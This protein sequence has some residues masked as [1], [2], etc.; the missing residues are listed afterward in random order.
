MLFVS[1]AGPDAVTGGTLMQFDS[2]GSGSLFAAGPYNLTGIAFDDDG[3]LYVGGYT[4]NGIERFASDGSHSTFVGPGSPGAPSDFS[5]FQP[6][7]I[8]FDS[9]GNLFVTGSSS[10]WK[11]TPSGTVSLFATF[12]DVG[13]PQDVAFD[14]EGNIYVSLSASRINRFLP[15]G[16]SLG[17]FVALPGLPL[18]IAF[19]ASDNLYIAFGNTIRKHDSSGT[20]L[21]DFDIVSA[22]TLGNG[23]YGLVFDPTSGDLYASAG[24]N[25]AIYRFDSNGALLGAF[26]DAGDGLSRPTFLAFSTAAA[27]PEPSAYAALV[28]MSALCVTAVWRRRNRFISPARCF[29]RNRTFRCAVVVGFALMARLTHAQTLIANGSFEVPSAGIQ[30]TFVVPSSWVSA[31]PAEAMILIRDG[32]GYSGGTIS[33]LSPTD[34]NQVFVVKDGVGQGVWIVQNV[35]LTAGTAYSLSFDVS[36]SLSWPEAAGQA[37][38]DFSVAAVPY[39]GGAALATASYD[40][41]TFGS[42][43]ES[44]T[45]NFTAAESIDYSIRFWTKDGYSVMD[46]VVLSPTAIPEPGTYAALCGLAMLAVVV[47]RRRNQRSYFATC[48]RPRDRDENSR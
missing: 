30:G 26:A 11:V 1:N 10:L 20:Y 17:T 29:A 16:E 32:S 38:P 44:L 37:S 19:D 13:Q 34:G 36:N 35:A 28:G 23:L 47:V 31:S 9:A 3:H 5:A 4:N 18:G 21:G 24:P 15:T 45:L 46:N 43:W 14:S 27:V 39:Y 33:T 12:T 42:S 41:T 6:G 22:A 7:G 8:K 2:S 40:L 25:N 48:H